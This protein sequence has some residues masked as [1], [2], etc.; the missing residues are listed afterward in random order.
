[1]AW[2]LSTSGACIIKAGTNANSAIT[3]SGAALSKWSDEAEGTLNALTRKDWV[4]DYASIKANFKP[5]LDDAVSDIIAI[6]IINYDMSG[7]TSRLEAQTMLDVI[8]DNL[9]R[10]L[11]ALKDQKNQEKMF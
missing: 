7:Y 8:K 1:M 5:A 4:A 10:N 9:N 6:R 11:D 3:A 2:T